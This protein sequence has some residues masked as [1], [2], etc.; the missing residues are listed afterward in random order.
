MKNLKISP[1]HD[2]VIEFG[3]I[4]SFP[5]TDEFSEHVRELLQNLRDL[6]DFRLETH[7]IHIRKKNQEKGQI[8]WEEWE[9][10]KPKKTLKMIRFPV[11]HDW[12]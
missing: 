7:H 8:F 1:I 10:K 9:E 5:L 4:L 12:D 3:G 6:N 11:T 2:G